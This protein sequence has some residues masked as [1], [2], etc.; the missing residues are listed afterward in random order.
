[1]EGG[2]GDGEDCTQAE[3]VVPGAPHCS[4]QRTGHAPG[5]LLIPHAEVVTGQR[6]L[7]IA[8]EESVRMKD[9][10]IKVLLLQRI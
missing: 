8:N 6:G 9:L 10:F 3:W 4:N 2:E 1:M 5:L 7:V